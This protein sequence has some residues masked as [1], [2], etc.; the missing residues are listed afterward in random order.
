MVKLLLEHSSYRYYSAPSFQLWIIYTQKWHFILDRGLI[1]YCIV[2]SLFIL[3]YSGL[4]CWFVVCLAPSFGWS[5]WSYF[6][7]DIYGEVV[8]QSPCLQ[9]IVFI[10]VWLRSMIL[11]FLIDVECL[12]CALF[13][14][15]WC[16]QYIS[17]L[18]LFC[19]GHLFPAFLSWWCSCRLKWVNKLGSFL[20]VVFGLTSKLVISFF[21]DSDKWVVS[22]C[23]CGILLAVC[24]GKARY[25]TLN[26]WFLF[27][28]ELF[29]S[30]F[31]L[32][33]VCFRLINDAIEP[34]CIIL[35]LIWLLDVL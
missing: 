11:S 31:T 4:R 10:C 7:N 19:H 15:Y 33:T 32:F 2:M 30:S 17:Q 8:S 34:I 28:V 13:T 27:V 35:K 18:H 3:M 25:P 23:C 22:A 21:C 29:I 9:N 20:S 6:R 14:G 12:W 16:C 24:L 26:R 5:Q 1:F